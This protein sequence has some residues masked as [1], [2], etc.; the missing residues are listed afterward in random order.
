[1]SSHN[2]RSGPVEVLVAKRDRRRG[3]ILRRLA[4]KRQRGVLGACLEVGKVQLPSRQKVGHLTTLSPCLTH[5]IESADLEPG[6]TGWVP[7]FPKCGSNKLQTPY[8]LPQGLL[9]INL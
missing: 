8:L 5:A 2:P 3:E 7:V 1:M 9:E 6:R 4:E